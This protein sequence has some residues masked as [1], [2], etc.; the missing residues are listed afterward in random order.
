MLL[1]TATSPDRMSDTATSPDRMSDARTSD[2]RYAPPIYIPERHLNNLRN[3]SNLAIDIGGSLAKLAYLSNVHSRRRTMSQDGLQDLQHGVLSEHSVP[4]QSEEFKRRRLHF[5]KFET[6]HITGI[7]HYLK[8]CMGESADMVQGRTIRVTGGGAHKYTDLFEKTMG[9]KVSKEDEMECL[10][11]G[12]NFLLNNIPNEA[13]T[14]SKNRNPEISFEKIGCEFPYLLVNIG[15]GVSMLKVHS[16]E[17]FERVGG[18]AMGGGTFWGLGSLLTKAQGFDEL[19]TLA[20]NGDSSSVD[21]LV[22]D[23]YGGGYEAMGLP[24]DVIASSFGKAARSRIA[25]P[26]RDQVNDADIAKSLLHLISNGIGQLAYLHANLYSCSRIIFGGFFIRGKKATMHTISYAINYWSK[27]KVQALFLR[28][29][30]YLGAVG[31]YMKGA[32]INH[33]VGNYGENYAFSDSFELSHHL[34]TKALQFLELDRLD[35]AL[36]KFPL[37]NGTQYHAD[38]ID[39][40]LETDAR[41][42]WLDIFKDGLEKFCKVIRDGEFNRINIDKRIMLFK[43]K[44][45]ECLDLL[46]KNPFA[47]GTL[48]VRTLLDCREQFLAEFDF[49]DP[50]LKFKQE[51]NAAFLKLL[52][53]HLKYIDELP[54]EARQEALIKGILGG[55]IFDWGSSAVVKINEDTKIDFRE[56]CEMVEK[57][58]WFVDHLEHWVKRLKRAPIKKMMIFVDNSGADIVMGIIPFVQEMLRMGSVVVLAANS[59]PAINDITSHE[60]RILISQIA[61]ISPIIKAAQESCTLRVVENGL[62]SPC[63]DLSRVSQ[64][65]A[66]ECADCDLIVLEG[67]GRAIHTNFTSEFSIESLKLAVIKNKWLC[68]KFNCPM[69][70]GVCK[71]EVPDNCCFSAHT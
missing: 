62:G 37:I 23:I 42:Y 57:R 3:A 13:F 20:E 29:E 71:Y 34:V 55:N 26:A 5:V 65:I 14:F 63:L 56:A 54:W 25:G 45:L 40:A 59:R 69:F 51:E 49:Y 58:P 22:K 10:I 31:A 41:N 35:M 68:E 1:T 18:T 66:D 19:L 21:L 47:Y 67:M 70:A 43:K 15:S 28:H 27:G 17:H 64:N 60:L 52:P 4:T 16:D 36:V 11:K 46:R 48:T 38:L 6:K 2:D 53:D 8:D 24:G 32:E 12:S 39:L 61:S 30:G 9:L 50:Y 33:D 7:T 44:F